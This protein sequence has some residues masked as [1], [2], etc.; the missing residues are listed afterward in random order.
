MWFFKRSST[1]NSES[2]NNNSFTSRVFNTFQNLTLPS[3]LSASVPLP[4]QVVEQAKNIQVVLRYCNPHGDNPDAR[5]ALKANPYYPEQEVLFGADEERFGFD[6]VFDPTS[7]QESVFRHVA[8]PMIEQIVKGYNCSVIACGQPGTGKSYSLQGNMQEL[9]TCPAEAGMIPR[10]LYWLFEYLRIFHRDADVKIS[11]VELCNNGLYDLLTAHN[12]NLEIHEDPTTSDVTVLGCHEPL[13]RSAEEGL[14]I[15]RHGMAQRTVAGTRWHEFSNRGHCFF[16]IKLFIQDTVDD[17][18]VVRSGKLTFVDLAGAEILR[19][20]YPGYT[21]EP[22]TDS[23]NE[24]LLTLLNLIQEL[25]A[26][27]S[28]DKYRHNN[29]TWLLKN[30]LG[31]H[32]QTCILATASTAFAHQEDTLITLQH[33]TIARFITNSVRQNAPIDRDNYI[34]GVQN[35]VENLKAKLKDYQ[36]QNGVQMSQ[37]F[38]H[39]WNHQTNQLNDT[40]RRTDNNLHKTRQQV[41]KDIQELRAKIAATRPIKEMASLRGQLA[42]STR[43]MHRTKARVDR[44]TRLAQC[45][46]QLFDEQDSYFGERIVARENIIREKDGRIAALQKEYDQKNNEVDYQKCLAERAQNHYEAY[47]ERLQEQRTNQEEQ[48]RMQAAE[49]EMLNII[50]ATQQR[51]LGRFPHTSDATYA[52]FCASYH[53]ENLRMTGAQMAEVSNNIMQKDLSIRLYSDLAELVNKKNPDLVDKINWMKK[54][55][56]GSDAPMKTGGTSQTTRR[57]SSDTVLGDAS[58]RTTGKRKRETESD[59]N[60]DTEWSDAQAYND[61]EMDYVE[62]PPGEPSENRPPWHKRQRRM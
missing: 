36:K 44:L 12:S 17:K 20:E 25:A 5:A 21:L 14:R 38:F 22:E 27:G 24:G 35:T 48:M 3:W 15:L 58:N 9:S 4:H 11:L 47:M 7:S 26:S 13:I 37:E 23:A 59:E 62:E 30:E 31:G 53:T 52:R 43:K 33:S 46:R 57:S 56:Y 16:T 61:Y 50:A 19:S 8:E 18:T 41:H 1:S 51:Y 39:G 6:R 2:S 34:N 42:N 40:L 49:I 55:I 60:W 29:L 32:T 10:A 45:Q 28:T 54:H